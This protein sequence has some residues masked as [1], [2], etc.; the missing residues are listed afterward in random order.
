[1]DDKYLFD[2]DPVG[3]DRYTIA[4]G[5]PNQ[6]VRVLNLTGTKDESQVEAD[7][8]TKLC[9][10]ILTDRE[11]QVWVSLMVDGKTHAQIA[12]KMGLKRSDQVQY[13]WRK[14]KAKLA[15]K[16]IV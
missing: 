12:R 15:A 10:Q 13:I 2:V 7:K 11:Y 14:A 6:V 1:M 16:G 4:H 8:V 5:S 3:P 9:K